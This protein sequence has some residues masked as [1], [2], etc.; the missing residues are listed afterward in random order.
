MFKMFEKTIKESVQEALEEATHEKLR[1]TAEKVHQSIQEELK[2]L[3]ASIKIWED[4]QEEIQKLKEE[5]DT[6][7]STYNAVTPVESAPFSG[8]SAEEL[9]DSMT[10]VIEIAFK[11]IGMLEGKQ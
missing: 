11:A 3:E 2:R 1:R 9:L 10:K 7:V 8:E 4:R 6:A 5:L